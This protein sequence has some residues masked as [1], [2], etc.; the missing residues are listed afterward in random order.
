MKDE[1]QL[2]KD[3]KMIYHSNNHLLLLLEC[4]VKSRF[5]NLFYMVHKIK[6]TQIICN[7][8][9]YDIELY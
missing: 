1:E 2:L 4:I 7:K 5:D 8:Q 6:E 3:R 9:V